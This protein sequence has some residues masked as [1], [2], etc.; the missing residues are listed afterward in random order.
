MESMVIVLMGVAGSGKTTVGETLARRLGWQFYDAD[1]F[2]PARNREKMRRGI[3]LDDNDRRPWLDAIHASIVQ[4]LAS[5]QSAIYACSALRQSYRDLL[6]ADGEEVRFV[7]LKG[8]AGLIAERLANRQGHFF[9][10]ALLQT[11]FD[12]LE[13]PRGVLEADISLPPE[14]IADFVIAALSLQQGASG[15]RSG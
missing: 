5:T 6:A 12:A 14:A 10:P 11:Q 7:Y 15:H 8:P 13:E 9:D 1:D 2:H 3:P 4:S